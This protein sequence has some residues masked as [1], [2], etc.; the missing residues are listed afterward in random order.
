MM[1]NIS[2]EPFSPF[3]W[4]HEKVDSV[5]KQAYTQ[6]LIDKTPLH[7]YFLPDHIELVVW[8][9]IY[10]QWRLELIKIVDSVYRHL[11]LE[12]PPSKNPV[13]FVDIQS[14]FSSFL[15]VDSNH[16]GWNIL[17][18]KYTKQCDFSYQKTTLFRV[19]RKLYNVYRSK[20]T[21]EEFRQT[22]IPDIDSKLDHISE[23]HVD[24]KF[25]LECYQHER[26][27]PG[28]L[29]HYMDMRLAM[30]TKIWFDETVF[31]RIYH[32]NFRKTNVIFHPS[33]PM[34]VSLLREYHLG[35][36]RLSQTSNQLLE[37]CRDNQKT[38]FECKYLSK[39]RPCFQSTNRSFYVTSTHVLHPS[40]PR[41]FIMDQKSFSSILEYIHFKMCCVY[42]G[43]V[44]SYYNRLMSTWDTWFSI[45]TLSF[46][47]NFYNFYDYQLE[48]MKCRL[49][50]LKWDEEDHLM[51]LPEVTFGLTNDLVLQRLVAMKQEMTRYLPSEKS[52]EIESIL[53]SL[54]QWLGLFV[55][56]SPTSQSDLIH[57]FFEGFCAQSHQTLIE[58]D[59]TYPM[60]LDSHGLLHAY[61]IHYKFHD[62]LTLSYEKLGSILKQYVFSNTN[63]FQ[64]LCS[65][66]QNFQKLFE[67]FQEVQVVTL[68]NL[69]FVESQSTLNP[70]QYYTF[71]RMF[72]ETKIDK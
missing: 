30:M 62:P 11:Q 67:D 36:I 34:N 57:A 1:D 58:T 72:F 10:H 51:L 15:G 19:I 63:L 50:F 39:Y 25:V 31:K 37:G 52:V 38:I 16:V 43:S 71:E 28:T 7:P 44:Y 60:N 47:N 32:D 65:K 12:F 40:F 13:F 14:P 4:D 49:A 64:Q 68:E 61:V 24:E 70:L 3:Y 33:N 26:C 18:V 6:I 55:L 29:I 59:I 54:K 41:N 23:D 46:R 21:I 2:E 66:I 17:G 8:N 5:M 22:S 53:C 9:E 56:D 27:Y 69:P 35:K 20:Y 42:Q 48:S 45:V